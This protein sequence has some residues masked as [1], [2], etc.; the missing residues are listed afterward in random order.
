MSTG[1]QDPIAPKIPKEKKPSPW[2]FNAPKFE[3]SSSCFVNAGTHY[4][5]GYKQPIGRRGNPETK[6]KVLPFGHI[7]TQNLYHNGKETEIQ[8]DAG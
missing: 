5:V 3:E 7:N 2:N 4:G 8:K 6:A 1:F